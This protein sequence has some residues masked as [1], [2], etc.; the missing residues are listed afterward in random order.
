MSLPSLT[1]YPSDPSTLL[2]TLPPTFNTHYRP[3]MGLRLAYHHYRLYHYPTDPTVSTHL[4]PNPWPTC[5]HPVK[6]ASI[7]AAVFAYRTT[8]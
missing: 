5:D 4:K 6:H 3:A 7:S 2:H 8:A 1:L